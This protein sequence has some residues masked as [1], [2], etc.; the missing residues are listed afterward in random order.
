[1][2]EML[3]GAEGFAEILRRARRAMGFSLQNLADKMKTSKGYLSGLECRKVN[4]PSPKVVRKLVKILH[5]DLDEL[6]VHSFVEKAPKEIRSIVRS[7]ALAALEASKRGAT[8]SGKPQA[9]VV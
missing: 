3:D 5:L 7:G 6:L 2:V 9:A 1:M 8:P 4:P